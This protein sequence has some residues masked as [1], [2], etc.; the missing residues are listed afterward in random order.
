MGNH[1]KI[2]VV[3]DDVNIRKSLKAILS[4]EGYHVDLAADGKRSHKKN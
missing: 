2:L 4:A 3:D 1:A